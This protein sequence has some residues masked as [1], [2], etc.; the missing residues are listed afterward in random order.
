MGIT[1]FVVI[2]NGYFLTILFVYREMIGLYINFVS[3]HITKSSF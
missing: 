3:S 2:V 1:H